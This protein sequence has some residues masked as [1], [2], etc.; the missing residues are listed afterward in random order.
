MAE[1]IDPRV[2]ALQSR[3][4]AGRLK[5]NEV[6]NRAGVPTSTWWRWVTHGSD[7]RRKTLDKIDAAIT[8]KIAEKEALSGQESQRP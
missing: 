6:L 3:I 8:A 5:L 4:F 7:P 1:P 2:V